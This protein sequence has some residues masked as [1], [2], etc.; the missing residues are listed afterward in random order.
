MISLKNFKIKTRLVI[1][2]FAF[3]FTLSLIIFFVTS[4]WKK[5]E[6]GIAKRMFLVD[7][8]LCMQ[9]ARVH[10]KAYLQYYST[11]IAKEFEKSADLLIQHMNSKYIDDAKIDNIKTLTVNYKNSFLCL[12]KARTEMETTNKDVA[13]TVANTRTTVRDFF[14]KMRKVES[15]LNAKG[16]DL[17]LDDRILLDAA[18]DGLDLILKIDS[19]YNAFLLTG[20]EEN[21]TEITTL[22]EKEEKSIILAMQ[23]FAV[24]S[25]TDF[26][27]E[28]SE[29]IA[30]GIDMC[31]A[32]P[33]KALNAYKKQITNL[34]KLDSISLEMTNRTEELITSTRSNT[35]A[36]KVS[37]LKTLVLSIGIGCLVAILLCLYI[38]TSI[39]T[40]ITRTIQLL[41]DI[42]H[43][44][45]DLTKR[46]DSNGKDEISELSNWFN[47]FVEKVQKIIKRIS[48]DTNVLV[49]SSS[50]MSN[51]AVSLSNDS[52]VLDE[53][54]EKITKD[55][56]SLSITLQG[57]SSKTCD[58]N[59]FASNVAS[60][61]TE[62]DA[63]INEVAKACSKEA[64]LATSAVNDAFES[65]ETAKLL[66]KSSGE[67]ITVIGI[68]N[69][70]AAQTNLLALNA[71][72]EAARAG[73][74]GKG[75]AVVANEVKALAQQS[76][77]A[78]KKISKQI[79][80]VQQDTQRVVDS[81]N[82]IT[83]I[84][85]EIQQLAN[86][87]AAS[88]EEQSTTSN[89]IAKNMENVSMATKGLLDDVNVSLNAAESVSIGNRKMSDVAKKSLA[90]IEES[91][92][93]ANSLGNIS[94]KLKS[95]VNEF[96]I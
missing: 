23:A 67:I 63:S 39:S 96:K 40:P 34:N 1:M 94:E 66:A 82:K 46:L 60:A 76:S 6:S 18:R 87:I 90:K 95:I 4:G 2:L 41:K 53:N 52:S 35:E 86:S 11:S 77:E 85:H 37:T 89:E 24:M 30:K 32:F 70:I 61:I 13:N 71:T 80:N 10:E 7:S 25:E 51:V 15:D 47:V 36:T 29:K 44:D 33:E 50:A 9:K 55:S 72:I 38:L 62:M 81:I 92:S 49:D 93:I 42:A 48:E 75:F 83:K 65:T 3:L 56:Q 45:G 59:S 84:I 5:I 54:S 17:S 27:T 43:G 64:E 88:A 74:S 12:V 58:V 79:N 19:E 73:A 16:K 26:A 57:I 21:L 69:N 20:N 68:V 91:T 31:K 78:T 14:Q 28:Y 8:I 22:I